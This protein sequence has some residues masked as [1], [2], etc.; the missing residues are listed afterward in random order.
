MARPRL[1]SLDLLRGLVMVIMALDHVRDFVGPQYVNG[2]F[3]TPD[4]IPGVG[5]GW[6]ATRWVTHLCAPVFV[7]LA[8]TSIFLFQSRGRSRGEVAWFLL[9]RGAWLVVLELT[10]VHFGWFATDPYRMLVF[11]VIWAIGVSMMIMA[12]LIY[13][14]RWAILGVGLVIVAGHDALALLPI[15]R[16]MA[17]SPYQTDAVQR[18][19]M[20][21]HSGGVFPTVVDDTGWRRLVSVNYPILP[22]LGVMACGYALGP[23]MSMEVRRRARLL[24]SLGVSVIVG[25]I[26]LRF[27]DVYGDPNAWRTMSGRAGAVGDDGVRTMLDAVIAFVNCEKYPASLLFLMMTLGPSLVALGWFD[28][29]LRQERGS[30]AR[31]FITYGRVPL[32]FYVLHLFVIQIVVGVWALS[33]FGWEATSWGFFNPPPPAYTRYGLWAVYGAWAVVVVSLYPACRWFAGMKQ[34]KR[35]WWV[36]YV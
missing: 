4:M 13:L 24:I 34:R 29:M 23:V 27:V 1:D 32:F 25:F 6:F 15:E 30:V 3:A 16:A 20:F 12:G 11:Q 19:W 36:S 14:P 21:V 18:V 28:L 9:T 17:E 22:W 35:G 26:V 10:V 2:Q 33:R 8:G 31:F 5:A 7:L